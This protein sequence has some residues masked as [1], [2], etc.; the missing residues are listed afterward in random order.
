M[1][2]HPPR[3]TKIPAR[4]A[5]PKAPF[6]FLKL[7]RG[8]PEDWLGRFKLPFGSFYPRRDISKLL[9]EI[10]EWSIEF[11]EVREHHLTFLRIE[12]FIHLIG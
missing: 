4:Q 10:A 2:I 12:F 11:S 5:S 3:R 1:A 8:S 6:E 7:R 9:G